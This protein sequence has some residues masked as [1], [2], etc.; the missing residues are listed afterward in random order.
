MPKN[1]IP[2]SSKT[3]HQTNH[4]KKPSDLTNKRSRDAKTN[5]S[6]E[7]TPSKKKT[8]LAEWSKSLSNEFTELS[9]SI[10][11]ELDI[12]IKGVFTRKKK[13][14]EDDEE[15]DGEDDEDYTDDSDEDSGDEDSEDENNVNKLDDD[16]DSDDIDEGVLTVKDL[17][18][19]LRP[20]SGTLDDIPVTDKKRKALVYII[21]SVNPFVDSRC[22]R[23]SDKFWKKVR[24]TAERVSVYLLIMTI[25]TDIA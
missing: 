12:K 20:F 13:D 1:L 19:D 7:Q 3:K 11:K 24:S 5:S 25:M 22:P 2:S 23:S 4:I 17:K 16:E 15:S 8:K 9:N 18:V 21:A 10:S 14:D 6:E